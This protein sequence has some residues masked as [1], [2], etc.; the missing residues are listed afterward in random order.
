MECS[1]WTI[2][3]GLSDVPNLWS[4]EIRRCSSRGFRIRRTSDEEIRNIQNFE[5][6]RADA[7][8]IAEWVV[9]TNLDIT[10][11]ERADDALRSLAA[12]LSDMDR[13]KDEFLATLAHEL[14]DPLAPVRSGLRFY[15]SQDRWGRQG[16]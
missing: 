13:C 11:R 16:V 3:V 8:G 7:Q 12:V 5:T 1:N 6:V 9:G 4:T 2:S 10:E 14:R 15:G